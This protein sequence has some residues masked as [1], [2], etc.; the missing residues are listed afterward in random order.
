MKDPHTG[1]ECGIEPLW[2]NMNFSRDTVAEASGVGGGAC[3]KIVFGG[4]LADV[5]LGP[6]YFHYGTNIYDTM[7]GSGTWSSANY[8]HSATSCMSNRDKNFQRMSGEGLIYTTNDGGRGIVNLRGSSAPINFGVKGDNFATTFKKQLPSSCQERGSGIYLCDNL[9]IT[10]TGDSYT[11]GSS[12]GGGSSGSSPSVDSI[13]YYCQNCSTSVCSGCNGTPSSSCV[14]VNARNI[15]TSSFYDLT[16]T[17]R[18]Y[19]AISGAN[20]G[21]P[22]SIYSTNPSTSVF[23]IATPKGYNCFCLGISP[24]WVKDGMN[25]SI[26]ERER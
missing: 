15:N 17:G 3:W 5:K 2:L 6:A 11:G 8:L 16:V 7:N 26:Q 22:S 12:S 23:S 24:E 25:V 20:C 10:L 13:Q 19:D 4:N 9:L 21:Q 14:K 18:K 1:L